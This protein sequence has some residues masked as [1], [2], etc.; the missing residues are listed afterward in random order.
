MVARVHKK[1]LGYIQNKWEKNQEMSMFK[2]LRQ[3]VNIGD[4]GTQKYRIKYGKNKNKVV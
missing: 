3:E 1:I 4:T 2:M